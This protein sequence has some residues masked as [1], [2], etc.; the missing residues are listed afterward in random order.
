[1]LVKPS[2]YAKKFTCSV[3]CKRRKRVTNNANIRTSPDYMAIAKRLKKNASCKSC[4]TTNGPWAVRGAKLWVE[5]GLACADGSEAYLVCRH[6]H[7]KSV[8]PLSIAST[9]MADRFKY[10]KEKTDE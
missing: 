10:Y 6:C 8:A 9:Y 4:G 5:D 3:P 2:D 7:L 1:M